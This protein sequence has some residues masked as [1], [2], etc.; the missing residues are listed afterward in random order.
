MEDD[1]YEPHTFEDHFH[2]HEYSRAESFLYKLKANTKY[3]IDPIGGLWFA[4]SY[5]ENWKE[6]ADLDFWTDIVLKP[7]VEDYCTWFYSQPNIPW[8]EDSI[9]YQFQ[10]KNCSHLPDIVKFGIL[11]YVR[12]DDVFEHSPQIYD[13]ILKHVGVCKQK[14]PITDLTTKLGTHLLLDH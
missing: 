2:S 14:E 10:Y 3:Y 8:R 5:R 6:K 7:I 9:L 13:E 11:S 12:L 1:D 4:D